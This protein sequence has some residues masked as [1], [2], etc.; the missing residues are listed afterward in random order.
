MEKTQVKHVLTDEG[1]VS[2]VETED[3]QVVKCQYF[4][5]AAGLVRYSLYFGISFKQNIL[6]INKDLPQS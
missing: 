3:G 6:Y 5:N 4:V 1:S 2:G